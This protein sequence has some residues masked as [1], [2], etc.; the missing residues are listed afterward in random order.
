MIGQ[1][2]G[3]E[4]VIPADGE[5]VAGEEGEIRLVR[6]RSPARLRAPSGASACACDSTPRPTDRALSK[7]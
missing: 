1:T 2:F 4:I 6:R 5:D 7:R 3:G